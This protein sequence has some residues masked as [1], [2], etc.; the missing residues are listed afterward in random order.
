M[1]IVTGLSFQGQCREAFEFYANVLGG[2]VA[3][4]RFPCR[5]SPGVTMKARVAAMVPACCSGQCEKWAT[6]K[7][8]ASCRLPAT[9]SSRDRVLG[10]RY[11]GTNFGPIALL[12]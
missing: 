6:T 8:P 3:G 1:K 11:D 5:M 2:N 9:A 7:W 10:R 4:A 12:R